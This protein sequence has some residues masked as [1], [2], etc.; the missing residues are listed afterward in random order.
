LHFEVKDQPYF[1]NFVPEQGRWFLFQP[2]PSGIQAIPVVTD[3]APLVIP[4]A[5]PVTPNDGDVV[6]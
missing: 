3:E 5:L 4:G 1:L 6:N 2:T